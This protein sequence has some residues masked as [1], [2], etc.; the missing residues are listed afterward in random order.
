M[1]WGRRW[2]WR[3][4][5]GLGETQGLVDGFDEDLHVDGLL[6]V[7]D[8]AGFERGIAIAD[9]GA[10]TEDDNGNDAGVEEHL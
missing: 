8:C 4:G 1:G 3:R 6:V 10:G 9:G 5:I 2:W 7:G